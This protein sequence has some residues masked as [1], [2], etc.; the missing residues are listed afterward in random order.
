MN[1]FSYPHTPYVNNVNNVNN[2]INVNNV[3]NVIIVIVFAQV[4]DS[5]LG[6]YLMTARDCF[7]D[8]PTFFDIIFAAIGD[9]WDGFIPVPA[10][11]KPRELWTGRQL[12]SMICLL[13][14]SPSPRD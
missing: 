5:L 13:Y 9:T 1:L 4:Q 7:I 10:I 14:T 12:L 3:N 11:L 8:K 6:A 2:V